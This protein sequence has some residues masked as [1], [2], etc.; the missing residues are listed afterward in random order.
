MTCSY[1]GQSNQVRSM[2][3]LHAINPA[4]WAPPQVWTP[5][6]QISSQPL[7]YHA[8]PVARGSSCMGCVISCVIFSIVLGVVAIPLYQNGLLSFLPIPG[9]G[10]DGSQPFRCGGNDSVR[11]SGVHAN[12]PRATAITIEANCEVEIIDSEITAWEGIRADGN[13]RVLIRNSTIRASG[14]GIRAGGNKE[15]ELDNSTVI[16]EGYGV[17]ADGIAR[18]T[19]SGGRLE[20]SPEAIVTSGLASWENRGGEIVSGGSAQPASDAEPAGDSAGGE[21]VCERARECCDAFMKT[22][23]RGRRVSA[24]TCDS[25]ANLRGAS[26]ASTCTTM[27]S[28]WRDTLEQTDRDVPAACR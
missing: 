2:K 9:L 15:I 7:H 4:G 28:T 1:C 24:S 20:G 21:D 25:V 17:E 5:P 26:F 18:V 11:I 12:L 13:R 14:V 8:P 16:A 10:W 6:P 22:M 27:M 3:T 19:V 23:A